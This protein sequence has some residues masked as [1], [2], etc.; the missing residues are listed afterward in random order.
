LLNRGVEERVGGRDVRPRAER[1]GLV[2]VGELTLAVGADA[3][4]PQTLDRR[5]VVRE[6]PDLVAVLGVLL[7]ETELA[8]HRQV[9]EAVGLE[10]LD[11]G[12]PTGSGDTCRAPG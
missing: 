2:Q 7:V 4:G 12:Q 1:L 3:R 11:R 10:L 6:A 8:G 5:V 9:L